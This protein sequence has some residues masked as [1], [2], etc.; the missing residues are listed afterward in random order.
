MDKG[1]F[2]VCL[3]NS[4][5][6]V[7]LEARKLY[8]VLSDEVSQQRGLLRIVDESGEDY[9]YPAKLFAIVDLP[10][11]VRQALQVA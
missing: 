2:A 3:D 7:S 6:P 11:S 9:L 5:Y 1:V 10:E 4:E 8:A